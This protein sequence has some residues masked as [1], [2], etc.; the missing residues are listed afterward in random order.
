MSVIKLA[1]GEII[2]DYSIY[3]RGRPDPSHVQR[4]R[5]SYR[6]GWKPPRMVVDQDNRLI[7]GWHRREMLLAERGA[8]HAVQVEQR[9]FKSKGERIEAAARLVERGRNW[10][11]RDQARTIDLLNKEGYSVERIALVIE[12]TPE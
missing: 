2:A 6:S 12:H 9:T 11:G 3:P 8:D 4:M 5:D 7:D 10:T 1:L